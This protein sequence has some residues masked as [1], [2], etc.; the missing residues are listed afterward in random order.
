[1]EP[2]QLTVSCAT[3]AEA[4]D[5]MNQA[6]QSGLAA[7]GQT[8]PIQSCYRWKG[9][10]IIAN[11]HVLLLKTLDIHFDA[12]SMVIRSTHSYEVPSIMAIPIS[13]CGPDYLDWLLGSTS[14]PQ[15]V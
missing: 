4:E 1:M 9:E 7:S 8:W 15:A 3:A 13:K 12:I 11:E 2:I 6:V 14:V 10:V 5:I